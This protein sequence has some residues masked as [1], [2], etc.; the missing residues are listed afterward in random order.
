MASWYY[1]IIIIIYSFFFKLI[2]FNNVVSRKKEICEN[3]C[4]FLLNATKT[5]AVKQTTTTTTTT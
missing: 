2:R 4:S 3:Y 1:Y 5:I